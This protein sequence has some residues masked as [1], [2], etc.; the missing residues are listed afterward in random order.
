MFRILVA[1]DNP[2][3]RMLIFRAASNARN[4]ADLVSNGRQALAVVQA[5]FYDLILMDMQTPEMDGV[6]AT[7]IIFDLA[8]PERDI[9]VMALTAAL[10]RPGPTHPHTHRTDNRRGAETSGPMRASRLRRTR[11][12]PSSGDTTYP[13]PSIHY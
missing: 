3:I 6:D 9:A 4:R 12:T 7:R 11:L 2:M 13:V 1:E 10:R 5:T 8:G